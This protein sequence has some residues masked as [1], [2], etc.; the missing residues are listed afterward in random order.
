M[1]IFYHGIDDFEKCFHQNL[2]F[3]SN[4]V[5]STVCVPYQSQFVLIVNKNCFREV[6]RLKLEKQE[7]V[8]KYAVG[9][10]GISYSIIFFGIS[11]CDVQK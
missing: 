10:N 9:Y 5:G 4:W 11:M 3:F 2:R 1:A 7:K 8:D 6:T